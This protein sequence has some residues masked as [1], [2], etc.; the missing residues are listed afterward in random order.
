MSLNPL[1]VKMTAPQARTH[2]ASCIRRSND[3]HATNDMHTARTASI[4]STHAFEFGQFPNGRRCFYGEICEPNSSWPSPDA[5]K[6]PNAPCF[7]PA[8]AHDFSGWL[9]R[10][11]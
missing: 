8:G 9:S 10:N 1:S 5:A 4:Q 7:P 2:A 6:Q 3:M 11:V